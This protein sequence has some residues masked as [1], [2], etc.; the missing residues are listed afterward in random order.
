[1]SGYP[2]R[3]MGSSGSS[4][5][6]WGRNDGLGG[7]IFLEG[8][9]IYEGHGYGKPLCEMSWW[10]VG[11]S[12]FEGPLDL[13]RLSWDELLDCGSKSFLKG[14]WIY[15]C[16]RL[17]R[18]TGSRWVAGLWVQVLLKGHWIYVRKGFG[19]AVWWRIPVRWF[20]GYDG[21]HRKS[22]WSHCEVEGLWGGWDSMMNTHS[23]V[24]A[25]EVWHFRITGKKMI[26]A[27]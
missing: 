11:P 16:Q 15:E 19:E 13:R 26:A 18:T 23:V 25:R 14:H 7:F 21:G 6:E 20:G 8:H 3:E 5:W 27:D 10:I 2:C 4:P 24:V 12:P 22:R 1:M 17:W 9:W